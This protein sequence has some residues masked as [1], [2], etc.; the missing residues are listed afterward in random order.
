MN[1][2]ASHAGNGG[3]R[4]RERERM[5]QIQIAGR[6]IRDEAVLGAMREVPRERFLPARL[7]ERAYEDAALPIGS[8]QTISQPYTVAWMLEAA[9]IRPE[10]RVLEIGAG[11]GYAAAVLAR[12][13]AEVFAIER[14]EALFELAEKRLRETGCSN[15]HLRR[16]DGSLGWPEA[17]PFDAIVVS[18]SGPKVPE[19]LLSQLAIGGRL[20]M[21]VGPGPLEQELLRVERLDE[22]SYRHEPLGRVQFVPLVGR[23]GWGEEAHPSASAPPGE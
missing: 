6:G 18:A 13:A 17:A 21:P 9:R 16:G 20:V 19:S 14:H 10:A 8:G 22:A 15:A 23:G 2:I 5:V 7:A 11:S 4:R 3:A 12:I 1:D